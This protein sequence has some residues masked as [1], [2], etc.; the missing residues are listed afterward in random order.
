MGGGLM[1]DGFDNDNSSG[2]DFGDLG[3][4]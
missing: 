1:G 2:F 3:M 4:E